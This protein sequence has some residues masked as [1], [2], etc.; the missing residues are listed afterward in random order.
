MRNMIEDR[1]E[2]SIEKAALEIAKRKC[3]L[4][5]RDQDTAFTDAYCNV[6]NAAVRAS[7]NAAAQAAGFDNWNE[8]QKAHGLAD[9]D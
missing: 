8:F 7:E 9:E 6:A 4:P 1:T 2:Y 5:G 3:P